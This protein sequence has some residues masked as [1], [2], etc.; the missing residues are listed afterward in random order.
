MSGNHEINMIMV[1]Q[2][3]CLSN[4]QVMNFFLEHKPSDILSK[5]VSREDMLNINCKIIFRKHA[6]LWL[7][8]ITLN[9]VVQ[10]MVME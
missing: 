6:T 5:F 8:V 7:M 3:G 2:L 10:V 1:K 4:T 9:V